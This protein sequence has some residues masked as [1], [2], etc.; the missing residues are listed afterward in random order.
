M[1]NEELIQ[2][3]RGLHRYD[4]NGNSCFEHSNGAFILHDDI[5]ELINELGKPELFCET[6]NVSVNHWINAIHEDKLAE[7]TKDL[8][9]LLDGESTTNQQRE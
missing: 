5:E 4:T 2:K 7:L 3:L 9:K 1:T 8:L 6:V